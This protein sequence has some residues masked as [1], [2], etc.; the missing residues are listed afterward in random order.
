M[1]TAISFVK[2]RTEHDNALLM[3]HNNNKKTGE[4][5]LFRAGNTNMIF[6]LLSRHHPHKLQPLMLRFGQLPGNMF[7][8]T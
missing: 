2:D 8:I 1:I 3:L 4:T 7:T 5:G 6:R